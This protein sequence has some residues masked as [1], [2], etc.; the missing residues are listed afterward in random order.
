MTDPVLIAG[1]A[2][3]AA[4]SS[5]VGVGLVRRWAARHLL[6]IPNERSSHTHPVPRGGGAAL[7][8]VVLAGWSV[9]A[10]LHAPSRPVLLPL[11]FAAG[12]VALVSWFDDRYTL[13]T[14]TRFAVHAL[15]V[16][17]VLGLVGYW[18]AF[19]WPFLGVLPVGWF[20]AVLVFVWGIGLTNAYN[21]MDGI[22]GIAAAQGLV[23]AAG[24]A[25][26][27]WWMDSP[28]VLWTG[29]LVGAATLGFVPHN[30]SPAKI[31]M[32][33]VGSAFLGFVFALVALVAYHAAPDAGAAQRVPF[34]AL[35]FVWP[36]VFDAVFTFVRR[37]FNGEDV[38][39]AHRSHLYQ[40]LVVAGYSHA[41]VAA[42]YGA[43]AAATVGA[44][45][46]WLT[47]GPF[48]GALLVLTGAA[49]AGGLLAWARRKERAGQAAARP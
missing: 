21:F 45:L 22:D 47:Q 41:T 20:G 3:A 13:G 19:A 25:V 33:D 17:L 7:V 49:V 42:A 12:A 16:G 29:V 2:V 18:G 8:A 11:A 4:V 23:A 46:N 27:G 5:A 24:W 32:G 1:A 39:A 48:A 37:L 43:C 40:R 30:W 28:V 36:F 31:F 26:A 10:A 15:G 38:F 9:L 35:A 14:R 34:A 6:D 44:G